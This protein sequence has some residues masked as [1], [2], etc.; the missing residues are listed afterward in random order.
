M[1][2]CHYQI[3]KRCGKKGVKKHMELRYIG[4]GKPS[5]RKPKYICKYCKA[6]FRDGVY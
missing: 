4:L 1:S 5:V 2:K 6:H 3:C